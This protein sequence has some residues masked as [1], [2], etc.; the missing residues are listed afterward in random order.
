LSV[1]KLLLKCGVVSL[2]SV[3]KQ[4]LK[5]YGK[6]CNCLIQ[7]L[8][9]TVLS[10]EEYIFF[11]EYIFQESNRYTDLVQQFVEKFPETLYL[12][13]MQFTDL[14]RHF[15]KQ[16]AYIRNISQADLQKVFA[17]KIEWIEACIDACG[18]HFQL[19]L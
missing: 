13:A 14:L 11:A 12:T 9:T 8:L 4:W 1:S 19:L 18:H 17:N 6:A 15:M 2:Y 7:F 3:V 5:H 16:A 10:I